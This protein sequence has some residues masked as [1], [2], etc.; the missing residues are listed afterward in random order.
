MGEDHRA[1]LG[2]EVRPLAV[3]LGGVVHAE[4][5]LDQGPV[6]DLGRVETS[7]STTSA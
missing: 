3:L 1:V 2:A 6:E 7:P 5:Q 4:E